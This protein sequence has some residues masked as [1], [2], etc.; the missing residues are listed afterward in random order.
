MI[1]WWKRLDN[2]EMLALKQQGRLAEMD[3]DLRKADK[4]MAKIEELQKVQE[5]KSVIGFVAGDDDEG[6][7]AM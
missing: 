2:L 7:V 3:K 5:G 4:R 6:M 1:F